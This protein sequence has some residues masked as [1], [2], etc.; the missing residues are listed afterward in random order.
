MDF[1]EGCSSMVH[2]VPDKETMGEPFVKITKHARM[3]LDG[4]VY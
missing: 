2:Y 4:M 3:P 1:H